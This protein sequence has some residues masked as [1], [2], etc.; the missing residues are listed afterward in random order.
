M[1]ERAYVGVGSNLGD[2]E[3]TIGAARRLLTGVPGITSVRGSPLFET[4]PVGGPP[5]GNYL[6]GVF[7]LE[8]SLLPGDLLRALQKIEE[9]LGR[10]RTV[11]DGPR[12]IDLDLLVQGAHRENR[13]ELTLPHPRM[14]ERAFVLEPFAALAPDVVHPV[15]G[16]SIGEHWRLHQQARAGSA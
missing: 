10:V 1:T 16:K 3:G 15:T 11:R 8:T 9:V 2:R 14:L 13:P 6:N 5:Q 7:E 4:L 12:T